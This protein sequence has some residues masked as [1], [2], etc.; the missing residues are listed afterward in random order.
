LNLESTGKIVKGLNIM[1]SFVDNLTPTI[2][3][4]IHICCIN[5]WKEVFNNLLCTIKESGLY[6]KTKEIR[7]CVLSQ[8]INDDIAYIT[9]YNKIKIIKFSSDLQLHEVMTINTLYKDSID[10]LNT[11]LPTYVLYLHTKGVKKYRNICV[12]DWVKIYL[13][14]ILRN[15]MIV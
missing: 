4:Y 9:Q 15:T 11:L 7:C 10:E 1:N 8:N 12:S 3:I 2:Y 5:N 6:N 13:I 14:L